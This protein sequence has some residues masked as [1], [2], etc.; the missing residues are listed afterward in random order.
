VPSSGAGYGSVLTLLNAQ[1]SGGGQTNGVEANCDVIISGGSL[2]S[3]CSDPFG[4]LALD[5]AGNQNHAQSIAATGIT[6]ASIAASELLLVFNTNQTGAHNPADEAIYLDALGLAIWNGETLVWGTVT[7][8]ND[9]YDTTLQGIGVAGFGYKL[10]ATQAGLAQ[11]AIDDAILHHG[12]TL[13]TLMVT[14]AFKA[15][16]LTGTSGC[17]NDGAET[18]F[19]SAQGPQI[20]PEPMSLA[21]VGGGLLAFGLFRKRFSA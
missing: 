1:D 9:L 11:A 2:S 13:S 5:D 19:L 18:I 17:A 21:L 12:A 15:G 16:C 10:D 14:G 3:A 7:T 4:S 20:V 8:L 6:N